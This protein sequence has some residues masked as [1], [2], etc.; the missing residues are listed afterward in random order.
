MFSG[1]MTL[2]GEIIGIVS[3]LCW[4]SA[5]LINKRA[6]LPLSSWALSFWQMLVGAIAILAIAYLDGEQWPSGV[7]RAMGLVSL[8]FHPR[9]NRLIWPLVR[10][11]EKRWSNED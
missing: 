9:V 5:T 8:A 3:A 7:T 4:A 6:A 10:G 1:G 11:A 2:A